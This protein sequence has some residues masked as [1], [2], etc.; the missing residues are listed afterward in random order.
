[1]VEILYVKTIENLANI[2]TKII[3]SQAFDDSL[4]KLDMH[5]IC[6]PP[7]GGVLA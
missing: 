1:M 4:V 7:R 5:D 2:R 6:K 3:S